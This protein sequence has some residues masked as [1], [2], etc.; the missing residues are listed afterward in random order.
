MFVS[1]ICSV[2]ALPARSPSELSSIGLVFPGQGCQRTGM[3][4]DFHDRFAVARH[5]YEE[6]S[7]ALQFDVARLCFEDD[8]R[9][10]LTEYAQP[11]ILTTEIAMARTLTDEWGVAASVFGGHSLGEY[12]ALVAAGALELG[13]T[14]RAVRERGRLMQ[15]AVPVGAGKMTAVIA[16]SLDAA[17]VAR[18]LEPLDVAVAN[19][20]SAGQ[21]VL[22]GAS[23]DMS[24][25]CA[26]VE[27]SVGEARFVELEVSA[28][29][30]S[31]LMRPVEAR[32]ARPLAAATALVDAER[33]AA[34]T[35]NLTGDFH[36]ADRD[37]IVSALLGQISATVRWRDNMQRIAESVATVIEVG[38]GRPLRG[39]FKSEGVPVRSITSVAHAERAFTEN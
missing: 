14:A 12:A 6:A 39:F 30:H 38:P 37:S 2:M 11:A 27:Q 22:S 15:E 16:P 5:T 26:L 25:A 8:R 24:A 29:F 33:A 36:R 35:S 4:R 31:H 19:D 21:V 20:N 7:E 34:V 28:P 1:S 23:S 18:C 32:F 10:A 3:G 13:P 9:L 17:S